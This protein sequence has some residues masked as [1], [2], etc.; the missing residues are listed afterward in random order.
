MKDEKKLSRIT[1]NSFFSPQSATKHN[2]CYY[3]KNKINSIILYIF[4]A[5]CSEGFIFCSRTK[6]PSHPKQKNKP[7]SVSERSSPTKK[8]KVF[9]LVF[10]THHSFSPLYA[11]F[12]FVEERT[13]SSNGKHALQHFGT[14]LSSQVIG[15]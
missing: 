3:T 15:C 2:I 6:K 10:F 4:A 7:N 14:S 12:T 11:C 9:H 5:S 8:K 13:S 1:T